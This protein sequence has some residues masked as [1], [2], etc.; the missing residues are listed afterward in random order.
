M[1]ASEHGWLQSAVSPYEKETRLRLGASAANHFPLLI[2]LGN[3]QFRLFK[4]LRSLV[5]CKECTQTVARVITQ[6]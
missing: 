2:I 5:I 3:V 1:R 4:A 6:N